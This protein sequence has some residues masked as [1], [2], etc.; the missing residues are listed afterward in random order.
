MRLLGS[1]S[2]AARLE[3]RRL[4][5]RA[6]ELYVQDGVQ[7]T[8]LS[9]EIQRS[10]KRSREQYQIDPQITRPRCFLT[11]EMLAE[12][13]EQDT[14]LHIASSILD[15]FAAR[16]DLSGHVLAY[17]D[18]EGCMLTIDGDQRVIDRVA[19]IDF[20][21]GAN[22][23]EDSA[24]TNGPGTA[25]AEGKSIEVFASEHF[26]TKWQSWSCAA[27]PIFSPGEERPVGLVDITGPW[28]VQRRQAILVAR[29][30]ARAV[31]ERLRAAKGVR[32]EVVRHALLS[33]RNSGDALFGVDLHGRV[34]GANEAATKRIVS[35]GSLPQEV[36]KTLADFLRKCSRLPP[37][38]APIQTAD[39]T[40]L[41]VSPVQYE[42]A[43]VGAIVR[44][45][46]SRTG[47]RAGP[48]R[49]PST[50]YEFA[51]ILGR[52]EPIQRAVELAKTAAR[53]TLPVVVYGESGTGKELFAQAIHSA[54]DRRAGRFVAVNCG[55][56]PA[57]LV[58]AELFGYESGTFTGARRD[59]NP[60]RFEDA[61]GGTLFL[62]E[63][64]EL[65]LQAQ[66]A[67]LRVLQEKEVVRLGGS[68]PR[69]VDVRVVAATNKP[70]DEEIRAKR[71]RR[72]LFYRLNVFFISV[73]PLRER[74]DDDLALLAEVFLK[75]A[76]REVQRCDL[77]LAAEALAAL[78]A[79]AWPGNVRELKNVLLR[80]AAVAP[81]PC[82]GAEDL[83]MAPDALA[84]CAAAKTAIVGE[85][86]RETAPE[87]ERDALVAVVQ[88]CGWNIARAADRLGV[89]RMTLYRRLH[90]CGISRKE[91]QNA[92]ASDGTTSRIPP[93]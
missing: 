87:S 40:T 15:D 84:P 12:R 36:K 63:V 62:D 26:V 69:S 13:R 67:L 29:A 37:G 33:L 73:P 85:P 31:E 80:A 24:A 79:H 61:N 90:R 76:E 18:A 55:S 50:R 45:P 25:L 77:T 71:F 56:I 38:E 28:E 82:I 3:R 1:P 78:R 65:P 7:P 83:M 34:I 66:T 52:S 72:D 4:V 58:E 8:D 5:D 64:S 91:T 2:P 27:A 19:D 39:G 86:P 89:S 35:G 47:V 22:W 88:A 21:P 16:L 42:G 6:W 46:P 32:D 70:L 53:N 60:G 51:R 75:E 11:P 93:R 54:S 81:R 23:A 68:T 48:A 59:G 92:P 44:A 10:W 17:L 20:R 74:G 9:V 43:S 30:I 57:Q 41:V 49:A 14:V